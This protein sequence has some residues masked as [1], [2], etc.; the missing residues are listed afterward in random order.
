MRRRR[1]WCG[2]GVVT[3]ALAAGIAVGP[4]QPA[5]AETIF[6][7]Y[8]KPDPGP[9]GAVTVIGDSVMLGSVLETDGYGPSV[10]QMLVDRGWGPV[11]VVAGVGLQAGSVVADPGANMSKWVI[12]RRAEGWDSPSYMVSLGPND[13]GNCNS[14]QRCA[15]RDIL[16]LVDTIGAD[17]QIW[18]SLITMPTQTDADVWNRAMAAVASIRPN[19][20]LW[21]WPAAQVAN[22]IRLAPDHV[23]LPNGAEYRKKSLLMADDFTTRLGAS[24]RTQGSVALPVAAGAP[25]EYQPLNQVRL[26][27]SRPMAS[28]PG[29]IGISLAGKVPDGTTAVSINVT[30]VAGPST[31]AG[32]LS[33]HP[34]GGPPPPTSSVNFAPGE[35]RPNQVVVAVGA[36]NTLCVD[37]STPVHFIVDLQ[38]AFVPSGALRL[39]P[40]AP[41][42][43]ADTRTS[44][45][46]DPLV[47]TIP[48]GVAGAVLNL[49]AVAAAAPGY[50]VAYPCD[51]AVPSTSN[52]NFVAGAAAAGSAYVQVGASGTVCVHASVAT[53]VVVDLQGTFTSGGALRFQPATPQRM[54]DTRTAIGGWR[55]QV[56]LGQA[57]DFPVAPAGAAAVTGNITMVSPGV[58]GYF[59]AYGC[60]Q[61]VPSTSSVNGSLGRVSA[62][63]VTTAVDGSLCVSSSVGAHLL[64]DTTGWWVS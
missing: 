10:A 45:R 13:I 25:G 39:N 22:G 32:Y 57:V 50:L 59:T 64:F 16:G 54:V 61:P 21:D 20:H 5:A 42:R 6:S 29:S 33:V 63:A 55:G 12:D 19:L 4:V 47:V 26:Y 52:V 37:A 14:Q 18:W 40:L 24:E 9:R 35:T 48:G 30:A 44:G 56:G 1:M 46:V 8:V 11:R 23:H 28:P 43:L 17:R 7:Q 49:T 38:G 31:P 60:G 58:D 41:S 51:S 2:F 36:T 53:D 15:E 34:C 62:N 27:D 3:A